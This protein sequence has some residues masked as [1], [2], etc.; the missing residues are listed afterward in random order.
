MFWEGVTGGE[1][2][3]W[4]V[5][6]G[7]RRDVGAGGEILETWRGGNAPVFELMVG[8]EIWGLGI[9]SSV[10]GRSGA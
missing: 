4:R 6:G 8:G 1:Q 3:L 9:D 5:I 2:G 7:Q 10:S